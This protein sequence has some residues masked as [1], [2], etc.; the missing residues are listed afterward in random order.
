MPWTKEGEIFCVTT[1]LE[2]K[3][4]IITIKKIIDLLSR[5]QKMHFLQD[6]F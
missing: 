6:V 5:A 1:Y 3:A 4:D 2:T